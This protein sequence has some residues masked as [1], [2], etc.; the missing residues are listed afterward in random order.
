MPT[1]TACDVVLA[2]ALTQSCIAWALALYQ[3]YKLCTAAEKREYEKSKGMFFSGSKM[4]ITD[5]EKAIRPEHAEPF[6]RMRNMLIIGAILC[7][8]KFVCEFFPKT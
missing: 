3:M 2:V 5:E 8:I 4:I 6:R 7:I 1:E